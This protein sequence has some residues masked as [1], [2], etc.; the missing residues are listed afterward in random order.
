MKQGVF[1]LFRVCTLTHPLSHVGS[2]FFSQEAVRNPPA[3][4]MIKIEEGFQWSQPEREGDSAEFDLDFVPGITLRP[5]ALSLARSSHRIF[6]NGSQ[7]VGQLF[8]CFCQGRPRPP[9][10]C[11]T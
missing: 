10:V 3:L 2:V 9:I 11:K 1:L 7:R 8:T 5:P 4:R 6:E